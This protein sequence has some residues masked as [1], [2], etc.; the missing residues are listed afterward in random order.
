MAASN[1]VVNTTRIR[2]D[3]GVQKP[4][5]HVSKILKEAETIYPNIEKA[6]LALLLA[7]EKFKVYLENHPGIMVTEFPLRRILHRPEM[8]GQMLAWSMEMGPYCLTCIPCI[9]MKA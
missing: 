1:Q 7:V 9:S 2:E 5:F 6:A 3:S 4:I 8:S